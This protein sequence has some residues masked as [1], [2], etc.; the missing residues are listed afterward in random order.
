MRSS[1]IRLIRLTNPLP[2]Q[3]EDEIMRELEDDPESAIMVKH[4]LALA[5]VHLRAAC[6]RPAHRL[7]PATDRRKAA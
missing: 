7:K 6:H 4:Y 2:T 3:V 1:P 5:D